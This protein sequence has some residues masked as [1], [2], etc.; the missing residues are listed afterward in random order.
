MS[1]DG[2]ENRNVPREEDES[3]LGN[4][5]PRAP[6]RNTRR[7]RNAKQIRPRGKENRNRGNGETLGF[8]TNTFSEIPEW[9]T[10]RKRIC[11]KCDKENGLSQNNRARISGNQKLCAK[12]C[13]GRSLKFGAG[14]VLTS[15]IQ[16]QRLR[17]CL[18]VIAYRRWNFRAL[19]APR[20]SINQERKASGAYI[21]S[22]KEIGNVNW[23]WKSP[24]SIPDLE[25]RAYEKIGIARN[26]HTKECGEKCTSF[27]KS[28]LF[29][30][31]KNPEYKYGAGF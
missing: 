30:R 12:L 26:F 6:K 19:E 14:N 18:A 17:G 27:G 9:D 4:A 31:H 15:T 11:V 10:E 28:G 22:T 21:K 24:E 20:E 25:E 1:Q 5:I 2:S 29:W 16:L 8:Y 3:L 23:P 13:M 7:R